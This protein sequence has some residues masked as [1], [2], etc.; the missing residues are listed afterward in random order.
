VTAIRMRSR[1]TGAAKVL[2]A[3]SASITPCCTYHVHG[4]CQWVSSPIPKR[5]LARPSA[6]LQEMAQKN[7]QWQTF[8]LF[9]PAPVTVS[10]PPYAHTRSVHHACSE[11]VGIWLTWRVGYVPLT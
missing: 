1:S 10:E 9:V 4:P 6:R 7:H 8:A 3:M 5:R 11:W 2:I